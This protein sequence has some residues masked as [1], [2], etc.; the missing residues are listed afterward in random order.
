M[1]VACVVQD[2]VA[3]WTHV[4][5]CRLYSCARARI[6]HRTRDHT[7]VQQLIDAGRIREEAATT[8]PERNRL[9]QCL[10]GLQ[11]PRPDQT[12]SARLAKNDVVLLCSDGFWDPL[13]QR[14]LLHSL[15]T[16]EL[17]Q[18]I[19]ELAEL[20]ERRAG[21]DERQCHGGRDELE[22]GGGDASDRRRQTGATPT[23]Q[24]LTA[25][26]LDYLR[27]SDADIEKAIDELK[28]ALAQEGCR[29][30]TLRPQARPSCAPCA[31]SAASP[32]TPKAR[33]WCEFGD[34][35]VLCTASVEERVPPFLKDSGRGWVT[36][37]YGMLPRATNTR[38]DREAARGKQSGR[39]QEIQRLI[40]RSLRAVVDLAALGPSTMHLDCDVLQADGGTRTAAITGAFVALH[41]AVTWL[42]AARLLR[43]IPIRDF[44][45]AVS[46]GIYQGTP[47]LDL[48]YAE[49]SALRL[50]HERG[51][52]RRRQ[53][54]RGA[55]H[56]RRRARSAAP[57]STQLHRPRRARHPRA[58][59][60][61]R[62]RRLASLS[63]LDY[64]RRRAGEYEA[65]YAKPERQADL[66]R[67]RSS[68]PARLAGR[69]VLEVA[70]GTGYWTRAR[71]A[72]RGAASSPP[73]PPRNPCA[74]RSAKDYPRPRRAISSWPMPTRSTRRSAASTR[75]LAV[76]WWS[77]V[78]LSRIA[79]FLAS[80][81]RAPGA[82]RTRAC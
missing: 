23:V 73:T 21:A 38:T 48:D 71:V 26:D 60:R 17:G 78:P 42:Q 68:I 69:R 43:E 15:L 8:H 36:A 75:A 41:D 62:R 45:A 3:Y 22:R 50:R 28:A 46:V 20:A 39:T 65:I 55:G 57:S 29:N 9:L 35:R 64:Y 56:R 6:L 5:D 66:A 47:V 25:T 19:A 30:E 79:E 63:S 18:A 2:G 44:V 51:H 58:D 14:Q 76:F 59:R 27:V 32:G 72:H 4:G 74:S 67:L 54:R 33:C 61:S 1:I 7:V 10:G 37:E 34:T 70:C 49:D 16:R 82:R 77:H 52:D 40:G 80:L 31:S 12:S 81:H 11:P 13:T 53:L 24:D